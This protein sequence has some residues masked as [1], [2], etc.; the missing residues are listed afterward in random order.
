MAFHLYEDVWE[1]SSAPGTATFTLGGAVSG[2]RSFSSQYSNADTCFYSAYDG[3]NF[4]HGLGTY[5]A[6]TLARTTVYRSTNAGSKV[7]FTG[8]VQV[9]CSPLGIAMEQFLTPGTTGY[10]RQTGAN[11]WANDAPGQIKNVTATND[12]AAAGAL[13]EYISSTVLIGSAVALSNN[14]AANITSISLTAGDW[15]VWGSVGITTAASTVT[16]V[17]V[18]WIST[19]SATVPTSPNNGAYTNYSIPSITNDAMTQP[20]GLTRISLSGTTTTYLSTL[21]LF[22]VS[23]M[24]AYGFIG[25]RRVR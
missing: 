20:V 15:D 14:V 13:G 21:M 9:V 8:T 5:S 16:T 10:Q 11:T 6:G 22:S 2:W 24:S 25:A 18:G 7:N 19:T 23:T 3:T 17:F 1:T 4:E 12:N